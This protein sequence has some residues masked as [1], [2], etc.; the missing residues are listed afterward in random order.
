MALEVIGAG[1]GR[2]GTK[3]LQSALEILGFAPCYHMVEVLPQGPRAF[4][5]WEQAAAGNPDWDAIFGA[6]R[7]TVDFPA[8]NFWKELADYY[9]DAKVL[10]SVRDPDSWFESTQETIF[11]PPWIDYLGSSVAA[12][13]MHSTINE[14]FGG[15]MHDREILVS[16]F[17]QHIAEVQ[18]GVPANRL[19]TYEV[20]E[21]WG[22]LCKF[23]GV[24]VPDQAF[25]RINDTA[26]TKGMID[27][28]IEHGMEKTFGY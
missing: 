8:C 25:P 12:N 5:L 17:K 15:Q 4:H 19:L 23:L 22:P 2:T 9:P 6:Y 16:R 1:F 7:A 10:L 26:E 20:K 3:S 18:A 28:M 14:K 24:A 27:Y 11:S 21:G 13:F